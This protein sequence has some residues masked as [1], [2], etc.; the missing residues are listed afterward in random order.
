[1]D[2]LKPQ[3]TS[4]RAETLWKLYSSTSRTSAGFQPYSSSLFFRLLPWGVDAPFSSVVWRLQTKREEIP[5][6]L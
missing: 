4:A 2:R 3:L 1:M 5:E 6:E